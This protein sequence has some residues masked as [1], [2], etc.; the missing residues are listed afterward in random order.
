M[1]DEPQAA[2]GAP[3]TPPPPQPPPVRAFPFIPVKAVDGRWPHP[4]LDSF[5]LNTIPRPGDLITIALAG[6]RVDCRVDFVKF[7]PYDFAHVTLG[8]S[9]NQPTAAVQS[10]PAKVSE[11]IQAQQQ[12]F[13]KAEAYSKTIIGLGYVGLFAIWSFVKDH[14]SHRAVLWT[15]L[16][17]G[18]SLIVFIAWEIWLMIWRTRLQDRFNRAIKNHPADPTKAINDYVEQMRNDEIRGTRVWLVIQILTVIPG[19]AAALVLMY[20]VLAELWP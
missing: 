16:L 13:Q 2:P 7:E 20:N 17:A 15:A 9:P 8:C 11:F 12:S 18:F 1:N 6:R 3:A 10:D 14:L 5:S 4:L 19:F